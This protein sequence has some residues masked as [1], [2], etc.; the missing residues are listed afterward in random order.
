MEKLWSNGTNP[1]ANRSCRYGKDLSGVSESHPFYVA[2]TLTSRSSLVI[3]D[4]QQKPTL[5]GLV[6]YF[7]FSFQEQQS[8][9]DVIAD[10]L[11]QLINTTDKVP[12]VLRH[13]VQHARRNSDTDFL[14]DLDLQTIRDAFINAC[15]EF[16]RCSIVLDALDECEPAIRPAILHELLSL[17]KHVHILIF[18]REHPEISYLLRRYPNFEVLDIYQDSVKEDIRTFVSTV[19]EHG[20]ISGS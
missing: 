5:Y 18:S 8:P 12:L 2:L 10:L 14:A 1:V 3:N 20:K 13:A 11:K 6:T 7:Y 4:L 16:K 19:I 9:E 17:V 15:S